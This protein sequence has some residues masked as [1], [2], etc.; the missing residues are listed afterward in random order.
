VSWAVGAGRWLLAMW[1]CPD[2][3]SVV[4]GLLFHMVLLLFL[5]ALLF[6]FKKQRAPK[7]RLY[8]YNRIL[9]ATSKEDMH[10]SS[11]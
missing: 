3:E 10:M 1:A 2:F 11:D 8:Y 9:C 6:T 7:A 4:C 5:C